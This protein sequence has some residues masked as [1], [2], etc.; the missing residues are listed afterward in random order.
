MITREEFRDAIQHI[1]SFNRTLDLLCDFGIDLTNS[2]LFNDFGVISD[3]LFASNF[4]D[5]GCDWINWWLYEREDTN[6]MSHSAYDSEGNIIKLD[7]AEE[8]W[9]LVSK[10]LK[11]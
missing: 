10:Y 8:L 7:T 4:T 1:K 6:S 9:N 5:E 11:K 3:K 2:D